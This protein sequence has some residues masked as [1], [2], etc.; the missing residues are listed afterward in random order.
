M[1]DT[2]FLV[3]VVGFLASLTALIVFMA[4]NR[5]KAGD[6][7]Y[8]SNS[9]R[10]LADLKASGTYITPAEIKASPY[11]LPNLGAAIVAAVC[12]VIGS[13][14]PWATFLGMST[15]ALGDKGT[16]TLI[17]GLASTATLFVVFNLGRTQSS[18][19]LLTGLTA[20]AL[21]G[22]LI[23]LVAGADAASSIAAAK[24]EIFDAQ[25][26]ASIGWGLWLVLIASLALVGTT[27]VMLGQ[28][29]K[30]GRISPKP[31]SNY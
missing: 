30:M 1:R 11:Y 9:I 14:A 28:L 24:T 16:I 3:L 6:S 31:P 26:G 12:I 21:I 22:G 5:S 23:S 13:F 4:K 17:L 2:V 19:S 7:Q 27:I 29:S 10:P 8:W 20:V 25:L 15:N 18:L